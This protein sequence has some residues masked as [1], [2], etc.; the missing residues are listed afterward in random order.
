MVNEERLHEV[1]NQA[2]IAIEGLYAELKRRP[3]IKATDLI[4]ELRQFAKEFSN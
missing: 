1:L 2:A 4:N 3:P